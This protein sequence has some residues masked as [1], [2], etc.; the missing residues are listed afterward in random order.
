MIWWSKQRRS[1]QPRT[2]SCRWSSWIWVSRRRPEQEWW[3]RRCWLS[4]VAW[5]D[6]SPWSC[7]PLD[8]ERDVQSQTPPRWEVSPTWGQNTA[9]CTCNF[10]NS[11]G[12]RWW[13]RTCVLSR[14]DINSNS[15]SGGMNEIVRSLSKRDNRTHWWNLTSSNSTDLLLP[16]ENKNVASA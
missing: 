12:E 16:P 15:P 10:R 7:I 5:T 3:S 13:S 6:S 8:C 2:C 11:G 1:G 14:Y 4:S 9:A